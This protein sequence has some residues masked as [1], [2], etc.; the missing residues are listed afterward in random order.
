[1]EKFLQDNPVANV[2]LTDSNLSD[3]KRQ[4]SAFSLNYS[5][6]KFGEIYDLQP[7]GGIGP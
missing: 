7:T 5:S 6:E 4:L 2:T 1:M 3:I